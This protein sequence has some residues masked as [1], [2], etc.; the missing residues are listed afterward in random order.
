MVCN[1]LEV[2][3]SGYFAHLRRLGSNKPS[4]L[5]ANHRISNEALLAHIRAIHADVRGEYGW[6]KMWKELVARGIRVG[7]ERVRRTMQEHGIKVRPLPGIVQGLEAVGRELGPP[8]STVHRRF[9][10]SCGDRLYMN[11]ALT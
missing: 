9:P 8:S 4:K 11:Q 10:P 1:L 3:T 5:G 7:K 2:S 6:P